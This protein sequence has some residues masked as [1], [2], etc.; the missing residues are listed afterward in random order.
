MFI[1]GAARAFTGGELDCAFKLFE[2]LK[3]DGKLDLDEI[4]AWQRLA[5]GQPQP[6]IGREGL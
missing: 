3:A 6:E 1:H 2:E 5:I 4:A